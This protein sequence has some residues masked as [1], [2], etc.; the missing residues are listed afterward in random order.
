MKNEH[1]IFVCNVRCSNSTEESN[2]ETK[3]HQNSEH[4]HLATSL[5]VT[6][7]VFVALIGAY[8]T[9]EVQ[10]GMALAYEGGHI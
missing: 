4:E 8:K 10:E 2:I 9:E 3:T 7:I 6:E 5:L 1:D